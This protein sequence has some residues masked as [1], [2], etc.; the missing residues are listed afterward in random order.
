MILCSAFNTVFETQLIFLATSVIGIAQAIIIN[1]VLNFICEVIG[2]NGL[3]GG[4]V[5]G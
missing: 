2:D 5:F 1:S 4:F 3:K